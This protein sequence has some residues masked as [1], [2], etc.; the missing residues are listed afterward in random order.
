M[1][2]N[3]KTVFSD[4][5]TDIGEENQ[6]RGEQK[7]GEKAWYVVSTYSTHET[8]LIIYKNVLNQWD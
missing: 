7:L 1:V 6:E 5:N 3:S 2:D 8:P 4:T